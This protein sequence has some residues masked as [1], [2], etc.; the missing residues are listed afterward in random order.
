ME[1]IHFPYHHP[2]KITLLNAIQSNVIATHLI[3]II[4]VKLARY[5]S[6]I[7]IAGRQ[8]H[9]GKQNYVQCQMDRFSFLSL[10]P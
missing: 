4:N 8:S 2:L 3:S 5:Q 6:A 10:R 1:P 7:S 9:D